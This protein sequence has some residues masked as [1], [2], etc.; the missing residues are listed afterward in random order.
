M[1]KLLIADDEPLER[2]AI[3]HIIDE[4]QLPILLV[5]VAENGIEAVELSK[6]LQPEI[7]IIDIKM[8]GMDGLA[9]MRKILENNPETIIIIFSAYDKFEYAQKGIELGAYQYL[10]KPVSS[11]RVAKLIYDVIREVD[12]RCLSKVNSREAEERIEKIKPYIKL[13][14][15]YKLISGTLDH[16]DIENQE[17]FLNMKI[18]PGVAIV[19]GI[20]CDL[21]S[22]TSDLIKEIMMECLQKNSYDTTSVLVDSIGRRKLAILITSSENNSRNKNRI[23][24]LMV[25]IQHS[26]SAMVPGTVTIGIG[27]QYTSFKEIRKSYLEARKAF[28]YGYIILGGNQVIHVNEINKEK[29]REYP[30]FMK[31]SITKHILNGEW[32]FA[33]QD[34]KTVL[35][36]IM[37]SDEKNILKRVRIMELVVVMSRVA[38][39]EG[40]EHK[41]VLCLNADFYQKLTSNNHLEDLVEYVMGLI[42]VYR[43]LVAEANK[44]YA[45]K[46]I[47]KSQRY[48]DGHYASYLSLKEV[49]DA[50]NLSQHYFSR[51]FKTESK[52]SFSEYLTE[53]R[54]NAAKKLL[55]DPSLTV[56]RISEEVGF[57]AASY[58]SRTFKEHEN[59]SP[60]EYRK[61]L[62]K[63]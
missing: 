38:I 62:L 1:Y 35:K 34:V 21:E 41:D 18:L 57:S 4:K 9:A 39:E 2:K 43:N 45:S 31:D 40:V 56:N 19:I 25:E 54:L 58:F 15:L 37:Q 46:I 13:S 26:I 30:V 53:K 52:C 16:E 61:R 60:T 22:A 11:D 51:L 27:G 32:Q 63:K 23:G 24:G 3:K 5:G 49:A 48:I 33:N 28:K 20:D 29:D 8:P 7:V 10:L 59:L 44:S 6:K 14:L 55:I 42:E 12:A 17:L 50:V 47:K 36:Q